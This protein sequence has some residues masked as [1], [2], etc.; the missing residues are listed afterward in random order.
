MWE[1]RSRAAARA[2]LWKRRIMLGRGQV[3]GQDHLHGDRAVEVLLPCLVDHAHAAAADLA[4]QLV[5]AEIARQLAA[6]ASAVGAANRPPH[7]GIFVRRQRRHDLQH[8]QAIAGPRPAPG[9]RAGRH[10][11]RAARPPEARPDTRPA[12]PTRRYRPSSRGL[13]G[14]PDVLH[15]P[16]SALR[17]PRPSPL[18]VCGSPASRAFAP[19]AA[20]GPCA[21]PLR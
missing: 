13:S 1:C 6:V 17:L 5:G 11:G 8:F 4:Q 12:V 14:F 7:V 15:L 18:A 19:P 20:N 3:A 10:R 9:G 2:S 21:G 16:P